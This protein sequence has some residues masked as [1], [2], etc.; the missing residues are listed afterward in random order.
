ML[1]MM[2]QSIMVN[3]VKGQI[4]KERSVRNE[5]LSSSKAERSLTTFNRK[6]Q[7]CDRNT[8]LNENYLRDNGDL[9][10][11]LTEAKQI[12]QNKS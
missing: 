1:K 4:N 6:F 9:N 12:F 11:M 8:K 5:M 10:E 7:C 3:S 2:E